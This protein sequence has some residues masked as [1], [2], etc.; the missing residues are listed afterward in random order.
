MPATLK[1]RGTLLP[2]AAPVETLVVVVPTLV[3][4]TP[5]S[6]DEVTKGVWVGITE[7]GVPV[8]TSCELVVGV[9]VGTSITL[10]FPGFMEYGSSREKAPGTLNVL[11]VNDR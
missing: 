7:A 11:V 5:R 2:T 1:S 10:S 4:G 9:L 6:E 8:P 3:G